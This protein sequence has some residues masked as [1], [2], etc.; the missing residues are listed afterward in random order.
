MKWLRWMAVIP[1]AAVAALLMAFALS[2][3][4]EWI[5]ALLV[6]RMPSRCCSGA[7][8]GLKVRLITCLK[9]N[10]R[11]AHQGATSRMAEAKVLHLT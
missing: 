2:A 7:S 11:S 1:S 8:P 3:W 9:L 6:A 4:A 10:P 5:A